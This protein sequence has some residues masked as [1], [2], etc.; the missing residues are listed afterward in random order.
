M[1]NV[2]HAPLLN[3]FLI[4]SYM[5]MQMYM[6]M[7]MSCIS[8]YFKRSHVMLHSLYWKATLILYIVA[9]CILHW[10]Q[11]VVQDMYIVRMCLVFQLGCFLPVH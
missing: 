10:F 11:D 5:Y 6:Y 3:T 1:R 8:M 2:Y 9:L 4:K 7:Y